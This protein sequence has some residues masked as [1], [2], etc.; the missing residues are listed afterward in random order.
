LSKNVKKTSMSD[1][2]VFP[3][4]CLTWAEVKPC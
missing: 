4:A 2:R 1:N 3:V